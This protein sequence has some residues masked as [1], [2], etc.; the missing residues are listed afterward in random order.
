VVISSALII[1][2][3]DLLV[4]MTFL[5]EVILCTFKKSFENQ[6]LVYIVRFGFGLRF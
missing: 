4:E 3:L 2:A 5:M 6:T 1:V